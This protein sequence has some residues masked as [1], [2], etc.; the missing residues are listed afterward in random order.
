M[1]DFEYTKHQS[2]SSIINKLFKGKDLA[3]K[4]NRRFCN[5]TCGTFN[6]S[7]PVVVSSGAPVHLDEEQKKSIIATSK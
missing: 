1:H 7:I 6:I 2:N 3:A 5:P 4:R